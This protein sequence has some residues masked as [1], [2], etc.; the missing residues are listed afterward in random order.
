MH[1]QFCGRAGGRQVDITG[2]HVNTYY[3]NFVVCREFPQCSLQAMQYI[4]GKR[5]SERRIGC[6]LHPGCDGYHGNVVSNPLI[7]IDD[8]YSPS[9][10]PPSM[11]R[12][13]GMPPRPQPPSMM[14]TRPPSMSGIPPGHRGYAPGAASR[15]MITMNDESFSETTTRATPQ[16]VSTS[17]PLPIIFQMNRNN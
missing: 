1:C 6:K 16:G 8:D 2:I 10:C 14:P 9:E 15:H 11:I 17:A 5:V 4:T 7:D 13:P 3:G 12:R